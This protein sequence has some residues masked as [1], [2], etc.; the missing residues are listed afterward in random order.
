[1]QK[2]ERT[3][4]RGIETWLVDEKNFPREGSLRDQMQFLL[5]YAVLAQSYYNSQ[6]WKFSLEDNQINMY[7]D[8]SHWLRAGDPDKRELFLSVGCALENLLIAAEHFHIG[9]KI[10]HFP[11]K[12]NPN[13]VARVKFTTINQSTALRSPE[14]FDA[15]TRRHTYHHPFDKQPINKS[16]LQR[17]EKFLTEE[18]IWL[19]VSGDPKV[20]QRLSQLAAHANTIMY[21]NPRFREELRKWAHQG[22]IGIAWFMPET[23]QADEATF[24]DACKWLSENEQRI[25]STAPLVAGISSPFDNRLTQVKA[26]QIFEKLCLEAA[27]LGIHCLPISQLIEV[28]DERATVHELFPELKGDPLVVFAMGY[29]QEEKAEQWSPRMSLE[30]VI[31]H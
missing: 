4:K 8:E 26:G 18:D 10:Q 3:E 29:G 30:S 16:D 5:N 14:L 7:V 20:K 11:D 23:G 17:I 27:L 22:N 28:P 2:R 1:M 9:H 31:V 15:I 13:L 25:L 21:E 12:A 19:E 24:Q 6:P